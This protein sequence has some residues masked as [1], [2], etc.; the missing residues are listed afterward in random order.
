MNNTPTGFPPPLDAAVRERQG[1]TV[2]PCVWTR[3]ALT[4]YQ[5]ECN[6][7]Y[8]H[9]AEAYRYCPFCG[10]PMNVQWPTAQMDS[11]TTPHRSSDMK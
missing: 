7:Q 9:Y 11:L 6:G 10:K 2:I 8:W 3:T 5:A 1:A 4:V